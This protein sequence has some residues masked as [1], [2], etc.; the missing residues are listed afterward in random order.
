MNLMESANSAMNNANRLLRLNSGEELIKSAREDYKVT[1]RIS[2][3]GTV[4]VLAVC[5]GIMYL[6]FRVFGE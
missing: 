4:V 2:A 3:I 5:M 1:K 6:R